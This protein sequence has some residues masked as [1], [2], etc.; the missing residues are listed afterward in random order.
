MGGQS[1]GWVGYET[2]FLESFL[3]QYLMCDEKIVASWRW[4]R[5]GQ[6]AR[7]RGGYVS[8]VQRCECDQRKK[9]E[10]PKAQSE[11]SSGLTTRMAVAP[12]SFSIQ[13]KAL[14]DTM[15]IQP[16]FSLLWMLAISGRPRRLFFFSPFPRSA[17]LELIWHN[18]GSSGWITVDLPRNTTAFCPFILS[19]I[20]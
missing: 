3:K 8:L 17:N 16:F 14:S 9:P 7:S 12:I 2:A 10:T 20:L 6:M 5:C 13:V 18:S 11:D 19:F 4:S 15:E 1:Q